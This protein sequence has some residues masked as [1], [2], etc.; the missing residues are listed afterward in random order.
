MMSP[1]PP[2]QRSSQSRGE[3]ARNGPVVAAVSN[4][5]VFDDDSQQEQDGFSQTQR[6][7]PKSQ[8]STYEEEISGT[9]LDPR[10]KYWALFTPCSPSLPTLK[11][12]WPSSTYPSDPRDPVG[13]APLG[14]NGEVRIGRGPFP[15]MNDIVLTQKRISNRHC[16]IFR[17]DQRPGDWRDGGA[18]PVVYIEDL[19][20]SNGTWV[21]GKKI[22]KQI[23]NHG[24]EISLGSPVKTDDHDARYIFRSVGSEGER[25]N[26]AGAVFEKYQFRETLGTGT[27]AEVKKAIEV[28]TGVVRAI[29]CIT[30]HK[31]ANN[32]KT[33]QLFQ[34]EVSILESL[35]HENINRLIE[36]WDDP[37]HV[38]LVLEYVDGGDLLDYIMNRATNPGPGLTEEEAIKLTRMICAGM[39]NI[40]LTS[41]PSPIVKLADFGL[42]KMVEEGTAL[43]TMVGTPQYLAPEIV[44][45]T[46]AQPGYENVVDSWSCGVI[47]YSMMTNAMP[48]DEDPE[49]SLQTRVQ[50]RYTQD[51]DRDLLKEIG[52]SA[53]AIDFID[54]LLAKNPATRMTLTQA[55]NHPWLL[56]PGA[57]ID[58]KSIAASLPAANLSGS[59][60]FPRGST[61]SASNTV[62]PS[63][64]ATQDANEDCSFPMHNLHIR[65]PGLD[66][67]IQNGGADSFGSNDENQLAGHS[68]FWGNQPRLSGIQLAA[69]DE[70]SLSL[71]KPDSRPVPQ[72]RPRRAL[73]SQPSRSLA[74]TRV[75]PPG[76]NILQESPPSPPLTDAAMDEVSSLPGFV[77]ESPGSLPEYVEETPAEI[78][79]S[80]N[81]NNVE[82]KTVNNIS[83]VVS[84]AR[85]ASS[86][87]KR[88]VLSP[89]SAM[90]TGSVLK[91]KRSDESMAS[92]ASSELSPAPESQS[93]RTGTI[94]FQVETSSET[95]PKASKKRAA[96][97]KTPAVAT[98]SSARLRATQQSSS[99]SNSPRTPKTTSKIGKTTPKARKA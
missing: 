17:V 62:G 60:D 21:N 27:F 52:I 24:D 51:F 49:E 63:T 53:T 19:N 87:E 13:T 3:S 54:K 88:T 77:E 15:K 55:L 71:S 81:G 34:R 91:R 56:P 61:S 50:R 79:S 84:P 48:F 46:R 69:N 39:S 80:G 33:L 41:D 10:Q 18:E 73:F 4:P 96:D 68:S 23:L 70:E 42:A 93:Q 66:R 94:R 76:S 45:Q 85:K 59:N 8:I 36:V 58:S 99:G 82:G 35:N 57:D 47:V 67:T 1:P 74:R 83:V 25:M 64:S 28:E 7:V 95:T 12:H 75:Q 26:S 30:K 38:Y 11:L 90:S 78:L 9:Q 14:S 6:D 20:S 29:K 43:R 89:L 40:L 32:P 72:E 37:Q 2:L 16:R 5:F 98:R 44:M 86:A 65:T 97:T 92:Q 31:F 22:S